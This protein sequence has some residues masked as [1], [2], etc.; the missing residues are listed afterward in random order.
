MFS[1]SILAAAILAASTA[2]AHAQTTPAPAPAP[3]PAAPAPTTSAPLTG[4][5]AWV[6][7]VGNTVSGKVDGKDYVDYYMADG[8]VKTMEGSQLSTGKWSLEGPQVCFKYPRE[9]RD[10][11]TMEVVG[12]VVTFK[13]KD[14]T[15]LRFDILDGNAKNL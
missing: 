13:S 14:G 10:C 3:A 8:T 5:Q 7:L 1:R 9:Q 11:Y 4:L 12:K 2:I 15:G 6:A